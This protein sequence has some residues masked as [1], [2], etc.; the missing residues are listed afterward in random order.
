MLFR[1]LLLSVMFCASVLDQIPL[2]CLA[3]VLILTGYKLAKPKIVMEQYAKGFNQFV[4]FAVTIIAILTTDLLKGMTI[5]MAVGLFFVLR[6]NYH[7][8]FTLTQDGNNYLLRMQKDVSFLNKAPLRGHLER[9]KEGA[10]LM[11]DGTR[12][13]FID[14]DILETLSDY[15]QAAKEKNIHIELK[16]LRGIETNISSK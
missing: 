9:I 6:T 14:Q 10:H 1:S 5:G 16:N 15:I 8:A 12:A 13:T 3:S 7:S 2:A 11:I 4:P